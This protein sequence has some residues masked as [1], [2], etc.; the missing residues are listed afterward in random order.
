MISLTGSKENVQT[1]IE[2]QDKNVGVDW[3]YD[4]HQDGT[5]TVTYFELTTKEARKVL[6]KA[7]TLNLK[8]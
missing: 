4:D 2:W 8:D 6:S 5:A 3:D 1:L 7:Y